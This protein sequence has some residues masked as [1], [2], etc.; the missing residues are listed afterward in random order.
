[1]NDKYGV[2]ICSRVF[3]SRFDKGSGILSLRSILCS[4]QLY[5]IFWIYRTWM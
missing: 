3:K 1:M 5:C 2:I 4:D